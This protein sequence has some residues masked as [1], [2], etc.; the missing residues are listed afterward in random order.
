MYS[1]A[2]MERLLMIRTL[3]CANYS[4]SAILR[5]MNK[6]TLSRQVAIAATLDTP[7]ESEEIVSVCDHLLFALSCAREDTQQMPA[8]IRQMK[9]FKT[10]Q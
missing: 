7:D 4:L 5:L 8:H 6:L 10:L 1:P 2:D 9:M 3:R